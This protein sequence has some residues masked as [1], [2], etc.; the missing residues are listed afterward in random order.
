MGATLSRVVTV[1]LAAMFALV[2][3]FGLSVVILVMVLVV[4]YGGGVAA[5]AVPLAFVAFFGAT[6]WSLKKW[7]RS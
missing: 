1:A 3:A 6:W 2:L 7:Q 4:G 5:I